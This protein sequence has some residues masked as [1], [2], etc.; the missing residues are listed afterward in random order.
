MEMDGV[1]TVMT[2][3]DFEKPGAPARHYG[4]VINDQPVLCG[5]CDKPYADRV[6]FY[7]RRSS[8]ERIARERAETL[9]E[10]PA[11]RID[12]RD[13]S[14]LA[15]KANGLVVRL[16]RQTNARKAIRLRLEVAR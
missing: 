14:L 8:R 2:A 11:R 13:I 7:G 5:P 9:A 10:Y 16:L 12:I 1:V 15:G 6:R 4:P 3:A